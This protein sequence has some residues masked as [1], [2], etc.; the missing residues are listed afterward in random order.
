[1]DQKY[2]IIKRT[3]VGFLKCKDYDWEVV[4]IG[5]LNGRCR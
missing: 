4:M 2:V 5:R 1:M 3:Q